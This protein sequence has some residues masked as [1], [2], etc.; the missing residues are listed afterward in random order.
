MAYLWELKKGGG[1]KQTNSQNRN[2]V[3]DI[4]NKLMVTRAYVAGN[5]LEDVD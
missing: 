3:T 4:E 5:N 2:T 1:Y